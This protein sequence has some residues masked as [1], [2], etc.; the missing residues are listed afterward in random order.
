ML[1]FS[2]LPG[3]P[4]YNNVGF[5][6]RKNFVT[7][8]ASTHPASRRFVTEKVRFHE[9]SLMT[10]PITKTQNGASKLIFS[11]NLIKILTSS[12]GGTICSSSLKLRHMY[13]LPPL[14]AVC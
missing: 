5:M 3:M 11:T 14:V 8:I 6:L 12:G 7:F 9:W 1:L 4:K 13:Y 2:G 10:F